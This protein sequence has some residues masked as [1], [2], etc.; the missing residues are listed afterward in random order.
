MRELIFLLI[1]LINTNKPVFSQINLINKNTV[2]EYFMNFQNK[3]STFNKPSPT[4][5]FD[6]FQKNNLNKN[7]YGNQKFEKKARHRRWRT[8]TSIEKVAY[9]NTFNI[10]QQ[11]E[12][13]L[14]KRTI[15]QNEML[16]VSCIRDFLRAHHIEYM[17]KDLILFLN[18]MG[19]STGFLSRDQFYK[20]LNKFTV[21]I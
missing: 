17:K 13:K 18:F 2:F 6:S 12:Q 15:H 16:N 3:Y 9:K 19:T 7:N 8:N 14:S 1:D 20:F 11:N 5:Y 21:V 4:N 10:Y